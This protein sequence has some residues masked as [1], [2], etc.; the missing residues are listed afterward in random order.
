MERHTNE[1][2]WKINERFQEKYDKWIIIKGMPAK[3]NQSTAKD[4]WKIM[5]CA[6]R[7]LPHLPTSYALFLTAVAK[8]NESLPK[9]YNRNL[10]LSLPD[11]SRHGPDSLIHSRL[12]EPLKQYNKIYRNSV[13]YILI[14]FNVIVFPSSILAP[15]KH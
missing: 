7:R 10:W 4:N 12:H 11:T 9:S 2:P 6:S 8:P 1:T 15:V 3:I 14:W 13:L 5:I